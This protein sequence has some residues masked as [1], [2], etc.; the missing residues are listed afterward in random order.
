[1]KTF[2]SLIL[3][4]IHLN[5]KKENSSFRSSFNAL[6]RIS[7]SFGRRFFCISSQKFQKQ[8]QCVRSYGRKNKQT[9]ST[10]NSRFL[11]VHLRITGSGISFV[12]ISIQFL[13][14]FDGN[15]PIVDPFFHLIDAERQ[16][17]NTSMI[18][19]TFD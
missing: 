16:R 5:D 12:H 17:M 8:L 15:F 14:L 1:M 19:R 7:T 4:I 11:L 2:G 10:K 6:A 3:L 13:N 18:S 9:F